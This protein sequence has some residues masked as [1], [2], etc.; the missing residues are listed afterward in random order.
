MDAVDKK[1][2]VVHTAGVTVAETVPSVDTAGD[3]DAEIVVVEA[4]AADAAWMKKFQELWLLPCFLL[5]VDTCSDR[6]QRHHL[7]E[8]VL[9]GGY[10]LPCQLMTHKLV[11]VDAVAA[12]AED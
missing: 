6:I 12:A 5:H 8:I 3:T 11:V 2:P 7:A 1:D 10:H 4:V 9:G